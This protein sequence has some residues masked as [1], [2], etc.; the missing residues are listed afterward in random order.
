MKRALFVL[1]AMTACGRCGPGLRPAAPALTFPQ[2]L[3]LGEGFVVQPLS[4]EVEIANE[5][6]AA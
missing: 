4:G 2:D 6:E 1:L 5:G 3:A